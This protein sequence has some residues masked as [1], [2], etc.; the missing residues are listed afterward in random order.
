MPIAPETKADAWADLIQ[1][2]EEM[3]HLKQRVVSARDALTKAATDY[4]KLD[5]AAP[6]GYL[7]LRNWINA[8]VAA[9]PADTEAARIK[10]EVDT[11]I[12]A[13]LSDKSALEAKIAAFDAV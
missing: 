2:R 4:G 8:Y 10:E 12:Q 6:S 13:F 1:I 9:N 7:G 11:A 3:R 5:D